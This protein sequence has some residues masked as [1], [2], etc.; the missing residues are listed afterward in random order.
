V[1]T[2]SARPPRT[3]VEPA[4]TL[5]GVSKTFDHGGRPVRALDRLDLAVAPREFVTL[6]GPSGCGK[7]TLLRIVG[8]LLPADGGTVEVAGS[9]PSAGRR[10]KLFGF[11]PQ[12]PAL[13]PWR[14]VRDNVRLLPQLNRRRGR[15]PLDDAEVDR[16][17]DAV[18]LI[19]FADALPEQLSGGMQQRVSLIRAFAL[20]PPILLMDEPFA[21]LD[22]IS[23]SQM[24]YL[25]LDLW[26]SAQAT[27]LFVTHSIAEA[28]AL[29]DRVVIMTPRPGRVLAVEDIELE[30][31]RHADVEDDPR[32]HAHCSAIRHALLS[33]LS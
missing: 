9:S 18:G 12:T 10:E 4:I 6:I 27:V 1:V 13:L 23:R 19:G 16:L 5:S 29:S 33:G 32:F 2:A 25:L 8:G 20:H 28:V 14:S 22:E 31:P 26:R 30:R 15:A 21:A 11:V 7:S 24:R 17:L 3:A